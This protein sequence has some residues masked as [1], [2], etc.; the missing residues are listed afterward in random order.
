MLVNFTPDVIYIFRW[1]YV[2]N[3]HFASS[4][5]SLNLFVKYFVCS[6][7]YTYAN[8]FVLNSSFTTK[9]YFEQDLHSLKLSFQ[10]SHATI[11]QYALSN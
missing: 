8:I 4:S 9:V 2:A 11:P 5:G 6:G 1:F 3:K 7:L 10:F